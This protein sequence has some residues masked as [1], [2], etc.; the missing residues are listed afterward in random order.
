[1]EQK[2]AETVLPHDAGIPPMP[3]RK[4]VI[5]KK[6]EDSKSA[7]AKSHRKATSKPDTQEGAV[8]S[9]PNRNRRGKGQSLVDAKSGSI[10]DLLAGG[11]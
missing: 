9:K 10:E 2:D 6:G 1:V 3:V 7:R 11:L 8:N 4:R 5:Q